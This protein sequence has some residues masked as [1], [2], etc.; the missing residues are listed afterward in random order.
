MA[1]PGGRSG[2]FRGSSGGR[3]GGGSSFRGSSSRSSASRS[4]FRSSSSANF[5]GSSPHNYTPRPRSYRPA[6][7]V[8]RPVFV[9][10]FGTRRASGCGTGCLTAILVF[11]FIAVLVLI[12]SAST[13]EDSQITSGGKTLIYDEEALQTYADEQYYNAFGGYDA[14]ENNILLVLLTNDECDDYYAIAWVGDNVHGDINAMMGGD[15][16]L[17]WAMYDNI[18]LEYYAYSL[19]ADLATVVKTIEDHILSLGLDSPFRDGSDFAP[20]ESR[21]YNDTDL[22]L[23]QQTVDSALQ[24]FTESTGIPMVIHVGEMEDVFR[25]KTSFGSIFNSGALPFVLIVVVV[26]VALMVR[27][28]SG[29]SEE[30][31]E[32]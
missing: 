24:A 32:A 7:M 15:T 27:R 4:S 12:L 11:I 26:V 5:R 2:G 16:E 6:R 28:K 18:N 23:T 20:A 13:S 21:L 22:F 30:E 14:Y 31:P 10:G 9:G 19:D 29:K 8:H 25:A 1:G 17:G 3:S